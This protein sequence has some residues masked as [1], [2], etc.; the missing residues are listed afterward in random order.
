[1][2]TRIL[3]ILSNWKWTE[4]SEPVVELAL[5]EQALGADVRF[6][7]GRSPNNSK[8]AV[9]PCARAKGLESI[10]TLHASKHFHL[11]SMC[12]DVPKLRKLIRELRPHV[13][14]SHML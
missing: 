10:T 11:P 12:R 4:R 8:K 9:A 14:H 13:V 2:A 3:H 7:C 1:M 5:A 6:V